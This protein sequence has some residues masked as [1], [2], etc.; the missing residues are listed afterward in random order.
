M[1]YLQ[2]LQAGQATK[3]SSWNQQDLITI[4]IPMKRSFF[5]EL[6]KFTKHLTVS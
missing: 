3:R 1:N 6:G 5:I 2:V 4:Q